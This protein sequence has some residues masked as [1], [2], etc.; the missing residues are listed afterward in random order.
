MI[1]PSI[2]RELRDAAEDYARL[3]SR[4]TDPK[5]PDGQKAQWR[6]DLARARDLLCSEHNAPA[7]AIIIL[8]HRELQ[9]QLAEKEVLCETRTK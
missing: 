6:I 1:E 3:W 5:I 4:L 2:I 9:A 7:L 8:E